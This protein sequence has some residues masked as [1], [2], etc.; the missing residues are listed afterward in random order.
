V[1]RSPRVMDLSTPVRVRKIRAPGSSEQRLRLRPPQLPLSAGLRASPQKAAGGSGSG[2]GAED[3]DAE[4]SPRLPSDWLPLEYELLE[5]AGSL[6]EGFA[7]RIGREL[8]AQQRR[9][10]ELRS[11][12]TLLLNVVRC[13][14]EG[15]QDLPKALW[16]EDAP[17]EPPPATVA[18]EP[19]R[20]E[21]REAPEPTPLCV[22]RPE[23]REAPEPAPLCVRRPEPREVAATPVW[24]ARALAPAMKREEE[25]AR[26]LA[27]AASSRR[28]EHKVQEVRRA[29]EKELLELASRAHQAEEQRRKLSMDAAG[30]DAQG[31]R[32]LWEAEAKL[33]RMRCRVQ[34]LESAR[35]NAERRAKVRETEDRHLSSNH[36]AV[37][38]EV[39][40]YRSRAEEFSNLEKKE[41]DLRAK[42]RNLKSDQRSATTRDKAVAAMNAIDSAVQVKAAPRGPRDAQGLSPRGVPTPVRSVRPG[43]KSAR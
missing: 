3:N 9:V 41:Q 7:E 17:E 37:L 6:P 27:F 4:D 12:N 28:L 29:A 25:M 34:Q 13:E 14:G 26:R 2:S 31:R 42:L 33:Q 23:P 24:A 15:S 8:E 36:S 11:L 1:L 18:P 43:G 10:A 22:R 39:T 16:K 21:P 38:E 32:V 19:R 35:R 5:F 20:P 30:G 40:N